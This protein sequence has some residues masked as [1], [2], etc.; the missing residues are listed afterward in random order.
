MCTPVSKWLTTMSKHDYNQVI[1]VIIQTCTYILHGI[2]IL[3]YIIYVY[4]YITHTHVYI[5]MYIYIKSYTY[6]ICIH[7]IYIY[8]ERDPPKMVISST[9][10]QG[11]SF[12]GFFR[13]K[14]PGRR[15]AKSLRF[16]WRHRLIGTY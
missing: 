9:S 14:T 8:I 11:L 15:L 1:K 6:K 16:L 7:H 3:S 4:I 5:Y 12:S 2:I 10:K 13:L